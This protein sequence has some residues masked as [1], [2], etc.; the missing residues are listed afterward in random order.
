MNKN[1]FILII[2]AILFGSCDYLDQIPDDELSIESV[3]NDKTRTEDWLAGVYNGIP[4]VDINGLK[5]I[6]G[7]DD[8]V[9]PSNGWN[10][11]GWDCIDKITGNWNP[12]SGW[13]ADYFNNLP[14][15]I[16]NAYIFIDHVKPNTEQLFT[17]EEVD[18]MKY[19]CK[20][21]IA[22]FYSLMATNYGAV[23]MQTTPATS[24]SDDNLFTEQRPFDEVIHWADSTL[25]DAAKKLPPYYTEARKYGRMTSVMCHAIRARMLLFAASDLVNGNPDYAGFTNSKGEEIFN[26]TKDPKKWQK[27]VD[28][29]KDLLEVAHAN[30]HKLYIELNDDGSIDPFM[31]YTNMLIKRYDGSNSGNRE[32]LFT[33]AQGDMKDFYKHATP[34]GFSGNGGLGVY[35]ELVDAFYMAN[36][37]RPIE[38][39]NNDGSPIINSASG[40]VEKGFSTEIDYRKTKWIEGKDASRE[41]EVNPITSEGTFNMYCNRE[42]R[43]Y[44]SVLYNEAWYRPGGSPVA[45]FMNA[46]DGGPGHDAPQVGYLL[47]KGIDPDYHRINDSYTYRPGV[48]YRLGEAYLGYAEA[49]NEVSYENNKTEILLYLN[50]IRERAGIP[51]YGTGVNSIAIPANQDAMREAIRH[52]RRVETNCEFSVRYDDLRRWKI[53]EKLCNRTFYR[54]NYNGTEKSD[55]PTLTDSNGAKSAFYIRVPYLKRVFQKKNYWAPIPQKQ[56]DINPNLVQMPGF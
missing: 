2:I 52:E 48:L 26:S 35:Q 29:Y 42:P 50:K 20:A 8:N 1:I 30:G 28:A 21:L 41:N 18:L 40:Y 15:K 7:L 53:A 4:K 34:R 46:K 19:E 56:I 55:D 38:G 47:R 11:Y 49:L 39:Y 14:K 23:P 24:A 6:D 31:S 43:F 22:Y 12:S 45:F 5:N 27:A 33:R 10:I 54:M 36:G 44:C 32:V 16:R 37:L 3:F 17:Q 9:A 13:G 25:A 51:L